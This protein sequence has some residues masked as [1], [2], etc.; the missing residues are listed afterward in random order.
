M[1]KDVALYGVLNKTDLGVYNS[2]LRI[3]RE[4]HYW[5]ALNTF[6]FALQPI[7][8]HHRSPEE[9]T[10]PTLSF[11]R[12]EVW[13]QLVTQEKQQREAER[14]MCPPLSPQNPV[15]CK[16]KNQGRLLK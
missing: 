15:S 1:K 9:T 8:R 14:N 16:A 11:W 13:Q 7:I 5:E 4:F 10:D 6:N 3:R 12:L 2:L